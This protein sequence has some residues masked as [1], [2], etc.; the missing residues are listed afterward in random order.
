MKRGKRQRLPFQ[1]TTLIAGALLLLI[2]FV[3]AGYFFWLIPSGDT[4]AQPAVVRHYERW[5][6]VEPVAYR[7]V[8]RR[9]CDCTRDF[10]AAYTVTV[11][12]G[13]TTTAFPIPVEAS[14]GGFLEVPPEPDTIEDV[15]DAIRDATAAGQD[16]SAGYDREFG[17]PVAVTIRSRRETRGFEVRD[18]EVLEPAIAL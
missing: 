12:D 5:H 10:L 11:Q 4:E 1:V 6:E 7:Y 9:S 14:G 8:V 18:F 3:S 2:L 13:R 17:F 16:V 15:F